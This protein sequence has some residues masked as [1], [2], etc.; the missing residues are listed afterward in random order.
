MIVQQETR[1]M[2]LTG[3]GYSSKDAT[4]YVGAQRDWIVEN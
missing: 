4:D 1:Q 3:N 2:G